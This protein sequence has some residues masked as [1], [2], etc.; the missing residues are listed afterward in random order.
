MD[1]LGLGCTMIA[2][3]TESNQST[4]YTLNSNLPMQYSLLCK[5]QQYSRYYL[6]MRSPRTVQRV[7]GTPSRCSLTQISVKSLPIVPFSSVLRYKDTV[8]YCSAIFCLLSV[9]FHD[10]TTADTNK[11]ASIK[12]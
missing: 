2:T 4:K 8:T 12:M 9:I 11:K 1:G 5:N 7:K 6:L 10:I 3:F